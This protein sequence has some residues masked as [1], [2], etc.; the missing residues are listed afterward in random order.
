MFIG[1]KYFRPQLYVDNIFDRKYALKGAF[2][3]GASYGRPR[4]IQLKV[5]VGI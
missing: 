2:F 1:G 3:S 4:S 5:N